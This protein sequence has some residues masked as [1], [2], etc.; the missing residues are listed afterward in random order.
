MATLGPF[1]AP[2]WQ[3][4]DLRVT[5]QAKHDPKQAPVNRHAVLRSVGVR[6]AAT[7]IPL[8]QK[9][10]FDLRMEPLLRSLGSLLIG[11]DLCLQ[12]RDPIFGRTQLI[13][14]LL[15]HVYTMSA[16]F[17]GNISSFVQKLK[18][19]LT[20][21]VELTVVVSSALSRSLQIGSLQDSLL[22]PLPVELI[23]TTALGRRP[24]VTPVDGRFFLQPCG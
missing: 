12:L 17:L 22:M 21:S 20:G 16:V 1:S 19:R 14:E 13:R 24:N 5:A 10:I 7:V 8:P 9:S 11:R 23:D 4:R 2:A 6:R 15:R 18:D 3:D